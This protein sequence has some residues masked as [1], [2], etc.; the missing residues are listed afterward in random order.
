M[1][2]VVLQDAATGS[3]ATVFP[4]LGFN[5][6]QFSTKVGGKTIEVLDADPGFELG[7][8]RP[9]RSGIPLLFPFPN[10]ITVGKYEWEGKQYS[11]PLG[12][13]PHAIHGFC[14][15][16]AWR[17]T[18]TEATRV[19]AEFQLSHDAAD[20]VAYWPADFILTVSYE[21]RGTALHSEITIHNP[22]SKPL[23]WGFG[24]H[25]YFSVPLVPGGRSADCVVHLPAG[26]QWELNDSLPTGKRIP[27]PENLDFRHG[28]ALEGRT[29]DDV[30][31]GV[32]SE[33]G[34]LTTRVVDPQAGV[35]VRQTCDSIF[36]ELVVFTPPHG[37][38]VCMEPYTCVTNAINLEK[39]G[40]DTGWRVLPPGETVKTWITIQAEAAH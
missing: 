10:R 34:V 6:F 39:Q 24:T 1:P 7:D 33:N 19:E 26:E 36:R 18:K 9:T 17:V 28:R 13:K 11:I 20:C 22:D 23:P 31:T 4:E 12:Q 37:R 40:I 16:R 30:L 15:D 27:V 32:T 29:F 25:T 5:C 14:L 35:Q 8:K 38:A 2:L 21:L 3:K